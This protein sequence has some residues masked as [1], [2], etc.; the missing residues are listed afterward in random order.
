MYKRRKERK[1]GSEIEEN[2]R[3]AGINKNDGDF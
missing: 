1:A 2:E 3:N